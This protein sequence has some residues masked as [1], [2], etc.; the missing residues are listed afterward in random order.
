MK[1]KNHRPRCLVVAA[2]TLC[3][4]P[5]LGIVGGNQV[6]S[7]WYTYTAALLGQNTNMFGC[8]GTLVDS[9]WVVTAAHC[10]DAGLGFNVRIGSVNRNTGGQLIPVIRRIKHPSYNTAV[11]QQHD[12]AMLELATRVP[13]SIAYPAPMAVGTPPNNAAV[14]LLGWGATNANGTNV[15]DT[16]KQLDTFVVQRSLCSAAGPNDLCVQATPSATSCA[17]DS[18]GPALYNGV[19]VGVSSRSGNGGD[20]CGNPNMTYTNLS[21]YRAWIDQQ[22]ASTTPKIYSN[23]GDYLIPDRGTVESPINVSGR[24]GNGSASTSINVDIR[25]TYIGALTVD[26][27][28]PDGTVTRLHSPFTGTGAAND[29]I[30]GVATVNLSNKALNGTW[31]L[32]V[33]DN[34]SGDTGY[35]NAWSITF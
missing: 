16:L 29:N 11:S 33:N 9:K 34:R 25:H 12:I 1:F 35:I 24:S 13:T 20:I 28:A 21:S 7:G 30:I 32:R 8:G 5:A 4:L 19:L 26:L 18:G 15:S 6:P 14:R 17:G 23:S 22:I 3:A 31:R 10:V 27:V 2:L